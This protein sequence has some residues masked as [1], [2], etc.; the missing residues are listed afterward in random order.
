MPS[1][2]TNSVDE[3]MI[4]FKGKSSLQRYLPKKP[5]KWGFKV[6]SRNGQSG[7]C[8]DFEVEGAPDPE[9]EDR[10]NQ[11]DLIVKSSGDVVDE[12]VQLFAKEPEL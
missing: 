12:N 6:F 4:P 1:E 5:K 2:E 11:V 3:Q 7:F 9:Q 8:Y 10:I